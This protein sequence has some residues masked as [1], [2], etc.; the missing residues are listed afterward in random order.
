[1]K[2]LSTNQIQHIE[3][4]LI[5]QY[6]IKYQD[7]RDEVLDHIACEIE[8]LMNEDKEYDEAFKTVFIRWEDLLK[9][10]SYYFYKNTPY[11]IS[12][13]WIEQDSKIKSQSILIGFAIIA[14]QLLVLLYSDNAFLTISTILAI[15][16]IN[17]AIVLRQLIKRIVNEHVIYLKKRI[18]KVLSYSIVTSV[19]LTGVLLG[20]NLLK[21]GDMYSFTQGFIFA[22]SL[23]IPFYLTWILL[24]YKAYKHQLTLN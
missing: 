9:T 19:L 24:T 15:V 3:E 16:S 23:F 4:F 5:S 10:D 18:Q 20:Q 12:K 8:E 6:H 1:M 11:Y 17:V 22:T 14:L 2:T 13:N 21:A 7:T